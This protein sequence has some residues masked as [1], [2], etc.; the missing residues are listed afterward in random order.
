MPAALTP[1]DLRCCNRV[2][3]T[4]HS[5]L[6]FVGASVVLVLIPGPDMMYLL[7]RCIAQGRRAG[8]MASLGF[9]LGAFTHLL[10]ATLGLSAVLA[11]SAVAFSV[12]KWLGAAYLIYLG[13]SALRERAG[14]SVT[15]DGAASARAART[16]LWQ[17]Y[18]S[19]ALNPKVALFFLALLPQFVNARAAHPTLQILLLGVTVNVIGL[20]GNLI[21]TALS[22]AVTRALRQHRSMNAWLHRAMG[23]CFITLGLRMA[24]E[25]R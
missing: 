9:S 16:I 19:D 14:A 7:G 2:T 23:A 11:T 22:S 25:R 1:P 8:V 13:I 18:L 4:L 17:A 3:M 10:A 24:V 15:A 6:L 5:Y 12:V 21:I 20:L